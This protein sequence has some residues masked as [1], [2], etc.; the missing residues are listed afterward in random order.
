MRSQLLYGVF[1]DEEHPE[2][3]RSVLS[4]LIFAVIQARSVVLYQLVQVVDL[5][6]SDETV[7]QRLKRF[8]QFAL[9][10]LLVARFICKTSSTCSPSNG[11]T[12]SWTVR[13]SISSCSVY[14]GR[15]FSAPWA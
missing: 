8:V 10:D 7:D 5:P 2:P 13:T 11:P 3:T 1:C 9:P 6:G 15:D 12:G 4:A 14:G